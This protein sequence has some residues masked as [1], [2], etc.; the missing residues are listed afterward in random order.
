M[1]IK[2]FAQVCISE[3]GNK[4]SGLRK[5]KEEETHLGMRS[6]HTQ[7]NRYVIPLKGQVGTEGE[8]THMEAGDK[9]E[10]W[11]EKKPYTSQL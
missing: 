9:G 1:A 3:K 4:T 2:N 5:P 11:G 7:K 10:R 6:P 8:E